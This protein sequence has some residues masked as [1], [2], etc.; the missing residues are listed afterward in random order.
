LFRHHHQKAEVWV[1]EG[2]VV[3]MTR[4]VTVVVEVA[5]IELAVLKLT[6]LL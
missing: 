1:R 6:A 5:E 3:L 2:F 4:K